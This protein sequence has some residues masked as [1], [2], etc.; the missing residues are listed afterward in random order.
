MRGL[1]LL[2]TSL[3]TSWEISSLLGYSRSGRRQGLW[4]FFL[5]PNLKL[6]FDVTLNG[7]KSRTSRQFLFRNCQQ[8]RRYPRTG[9]RIPY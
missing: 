7:T 6:H 5:G 4:S 9:P 1:E 8:T 3:C 2:K